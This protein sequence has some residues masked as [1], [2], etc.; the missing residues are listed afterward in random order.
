MWLFITIIFVLLLIYVQKRYFHMSF[1]TPFNL[2]SV[3]T[4]FLMILSYPQENYIGFRSVSQEAV[5][6]FL[7]CIFFFAMGGLLYLSLNGTKHNYEK[8]I[9]FS[10]QNVPVKLVHIVTFVFI[11]VLTLNL[12][13]ILGSRSLF[14]LEDQEFAQHGI[15]GHFGELIVFSIIFY[16]ASLKEKS[17]LIS[18]RYTIYVLIILFVF[19]ILMG[20]KAQAVIPFLACL[21]YLLLRKYVSINNIKY[22]AY[23]I[24]GILLLFAVTRLFFNEESASWS[25]MINYTTFYIFAGISGLTVFL[26]EYPNANIGSCPEFLIRFFQNFYNKFFGDG[27]IHKGGEIG[28]YVEVFTNKAEFFHSSNVQTFFGEV[29]LNTG[30]TITA[31]YFC[32][33]G[34]VCYYL[35]WYHTKHMFL[36]ILYAYIGAILVMSFFSSYALGQG[37]YETSVFCILLYRIFRNYS[38]KKSLR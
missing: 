1:Y 11:L 15:E 22:I 24:V 12:N 38:R 2:I 26:E 19:K 37:F 4:L 18:K 16:Y 33:L 5:F 27:S 3:P 14:Q 36:T 34:F 25:Y 35:Y 23:S 13:S 29:Y 10:N 20:V 30:Y 31:L 17:L 6:I 32:L 28:G 7:Y 9:V 8:Q 21:L